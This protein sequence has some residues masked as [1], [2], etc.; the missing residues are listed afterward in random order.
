MVLTLPA[1]TTNGTISPLNPAPDPYILRATKQALPLPLHNLA[2]VR[3][4]SLA[5]TTNTASPAERFGLQFGG[6]DNLITFNKPVHFGTAY[7]IE[8]WFKSNHQSKQIIFAALNEN[9]KHHLLLELSPQNNKQ[10]RYVQRVPAG[11]IGG[12]SAY[13]LR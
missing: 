13:S 6:Q 11:S 1:L 5:S 10:V 4:L 9:N 8:G 7:T 12:S 2:A 3:P